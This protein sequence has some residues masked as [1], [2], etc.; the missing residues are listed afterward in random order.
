MFRSNV[1]HVFIP[2]VDYIVW[3][4][5]PFNE[6]SW[7]WSHLT[8]HGIVLLF[9]HFCDI[10]WYALLLSSLVCFDMAMKAFFLLWHTSMSR[11]AQIYLCDIVI[12][13]D[14]YRLNRFRFLALFNTISVKILW[15][16]SSTLQFI[17]SWRGTVLI[18]LHEDGKSFVETLASQ[19]S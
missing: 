4:G 15:K 17:I 8:L 14:S 6:T 1:V 16:Q 19:I 13:S 2:W 12:E 9:I 18:L 10:H 11:S 7:Q 5:T 3:F